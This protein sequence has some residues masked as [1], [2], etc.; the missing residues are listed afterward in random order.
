M[1]NFR[2][3]ICQKALLRKVEG[4]NS[5]W[6]ATAKLVISMLSYIPTFLILYDK[7][8]MTK[9]ASPYTNGWVSVSCATLNKA[10]CWS[11]NAA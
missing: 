3:V 6:L 4:N 11:I 7:P 1:L 2:G 8:Y 5:Q 10:L 9:A